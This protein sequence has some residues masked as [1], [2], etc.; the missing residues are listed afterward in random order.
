M[1]SDSSHCL[2]VLSYTIYSCAMRQNKNT[3]ELFNYSIFRERHMRAKISNE[4]QIV[5]VIILCQWNKKGTKYPQVFNIENF[6]VL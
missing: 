1:T 2:N 3:N 6:S 4:R 5:D